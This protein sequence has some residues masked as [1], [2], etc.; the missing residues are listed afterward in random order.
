[1]SPAPKCLKRGMFLPANP[2][3][4][5]VQLK[6]QKMTLAYVQVLQYWAEE[7]NLPAPSEPHPLAMSVRELRWCIGKYNTFNKHDVFEDL[8]NALPE[9]KAE[10]MG[11]SPADFTTSSAMTDA[12]DTQPSPV[13]APPADDTTVPVA[14]SNTRIQKDMPA[15]GMLALL[16][17]KIWLPPL[18]YWWIGWL[19]FPLQLAI[20]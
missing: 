20:Q 18:P 2:S 4:Q 1:M 11:T 7:A 9:A 14:E 8:G 17:W 10:D 12:E 6:P 19:V 15:P 5:D 13:E 16:D 3:Y